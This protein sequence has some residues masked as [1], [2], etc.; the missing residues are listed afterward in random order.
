MPASSPNKVTVVRLACVTL[1][2]SNK[3]NMESLRRYCATSA[4]G[5]GGGGG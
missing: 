2:S 4:G 3:G 1:S 5:G